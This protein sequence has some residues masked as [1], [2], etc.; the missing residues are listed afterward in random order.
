MTDDFAD[1]MHYTVRMHP[2]HANDIGFPALTEGAAIAVAVSGGA[3]SMAL[4]HLL[5]DWARMRALTLHALTVDH[6]LRP[7][8]ALEAEQVARWCATMGIAHY[9][10]AWE[11]GPL[12][13]GI[14]NKAREARYALMGAW[15]RAH[16][17]RDL[18]TA[19]HA[20]D[21]QETFLLRLLAQSGPEGLGGIRPLSRRD[22][23]NL[24][25]PLLHLP[26]E[27]LL[28]YLRAGGHEWLED[29]SNDSHDY[30]RNRLRRFLD[31]LPNNQKKRVS[32]LTESFFIFREYMDNHRH[33]ALQ[34]TMC[35]HEA[36]F[37]MMDHESWLMLPPLLQ[38][39]V[40]EQACQLASGNASPIR[41]EKLM[42]LRDSVQAKKKAT[43]HGAVFIHEAKRNRWLIVREKKRMEGKRKI[44]PYSQRWD[45]RFEVSSA[46]ANLLIGA[47]GTPAKEW[48]Q[49][50]ERSNI[51]KAAWPTLPVIFHL[52]EC[53]SIPH[54]DGGF[55]GVTL[56][57]D[58][59]KLLAKARKSAM[60]LGLNGKQGAKARA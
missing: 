19:H 37:G 26:K 28:A 8:S 15:C 53:V 5:H 17:V 39:S 27:R 4:L 32:Q 42:R 2:L 33:Q 10:L 58:A 16:G 57:H 20:D 56:L 11:H 46:H 59:P 45:G 41:S 13:G 49:R 12:S 1:R 47:L 36:G 52:E 31:A 44:V 43:L 29:P 18:F 7:E 40:L 6:R 35:W 30:T 50:L 60:N 3:D 48:R 9:T 51:P 34:E 21:Q 23:I 22:G 54:I 38:K 14:Q 25:R 55:T 24:H